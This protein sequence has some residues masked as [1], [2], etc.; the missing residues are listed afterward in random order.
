MAKVL[1][2][3]VNT[4]REDGAKIVLRAGD[5]VPTLIEGELDR[6]VKL[7]AIEAAKIAKVIAPEAK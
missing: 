3:V 7:G 2:E 5:E 4:I 1:S 6:L